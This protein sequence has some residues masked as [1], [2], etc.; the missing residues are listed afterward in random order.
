MGRDSTK[1]SASLFNDLVSAGEDCRGN[2]QTQ[3]LRGSQIHQQ[4]EGCGLLHRQLAG[5]RAFQDLVDVIRSPAEQIVEI[6]RV[7]DETPRLSKF[8]EWIYPG[9]PLTAMNTTIGVR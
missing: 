2:G 7:E 1:K 8:P 4:F 6:S 9:S 5:L 3:R